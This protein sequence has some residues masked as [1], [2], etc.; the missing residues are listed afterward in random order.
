MTV[1]FFV[2]WF[3]GPFM[4]NENHIH[5]ESL[6]QKQIY[7]LVGYLIDEFGNELSRDELDES[8]GIVMENV[9]GLELVSPRKI[10]QLIEQIRSRYHDQVQSI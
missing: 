10:H 7:E 5:F 3:D 1:V 2:N 8:I 4:T 9:P 6:T